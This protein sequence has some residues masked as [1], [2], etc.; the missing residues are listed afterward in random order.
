MSNDRH[1]RSEFLQV[2]GV[3]A[4]K[5]I[6][7]LFLTFA[8]QQDDDGLLSR[9]ELFD[10]T[11][12][13]VVLTLASEFDFQ[14]EKERAFEEQS[15]PTNEQICRCACVSVLALDDRVAGAGVAQEL[16]QARLVSPLIL[17]DAGL[18][19][20]QVVPDRSDP[21]PSDARLW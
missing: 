21:V 15:G 18:P 6:D 13:P 17:E 1:G 8:D 16:F 10:L 9:A 12:Q 5:S 11:D 20:P 4:V 2:V 19:V 7:E 14:L 3:A